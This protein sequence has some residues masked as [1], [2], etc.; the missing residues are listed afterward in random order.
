MKIRV[1]ILSYMLVGALFNAV[2]AELI[3][4]MH[5]FFESKMKGRLGKAV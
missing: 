4:P 5:A 2:L 3:F 1:R